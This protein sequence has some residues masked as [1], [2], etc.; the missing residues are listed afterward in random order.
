M[1]RLA[2]GKFA[3]NL[4]EHFFSTNTRKNKNKIHVNRG[5]VK[6]DASAKQSKKNVDSSK[7]DENIHLN[8]KKC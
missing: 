8:H 4:Q 3:E 2:D 6:T 1:K 5:T 7:N